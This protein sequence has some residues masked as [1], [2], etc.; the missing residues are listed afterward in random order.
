MKNSSEEKAG[1]KAR[2]NKATTAKDPNV[3]KTV[4]DDWADGYDADI[5]GYGYVAPE[6]CVK[7]LMDL[8]PEKSSLIY[9]AGCGTGLIGQRLKQSGYGRVEGADF[10]P[11]MLEKAK[12]T[13]A[14]RSLEL[15]DYSKPLP[16]VASRTYDGVI[17]VGVYCAGFREHFLNEMLRVLKPGGALVMTAR[18]HFYEGE[19]EV[20]LQK[21]VDAGLITDL[22]VSV[23][24]YMQGQ[25]T[26]AYYI[27]ARKSVRKT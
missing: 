14:Y 10:S 4:Y 8:L 21:L 19:I 9:D 24:A 17:S 11:E 1:L 13:G 22:D 5:T 2:I 20:D 3:V 6:I 27:R 7:S 25:N 18:A 23:Q 15:S 12:A 26:E 16:H